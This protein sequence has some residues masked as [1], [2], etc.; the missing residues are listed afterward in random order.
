MLKV[1]RAHLIY[2][3]YLKLVP[4]QCYKLIYDSKISKA[5]FTWNERETELHISFSSPL[6]HSPSTVSFWNSL[7]SASKALIA[8]SPWSIGRSV[9]LSLSY[10]SFVFDLNLNVFHCHSCVHLETITNPNRWSPECIDNLLRV[11]FFQ[12]CWLRT[13]LCIRVIRR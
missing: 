11:Y 8:K 3:I 12:T 5:D 6:L 2:G 1:S 9:F 10:L 7:T 4:K 13:F